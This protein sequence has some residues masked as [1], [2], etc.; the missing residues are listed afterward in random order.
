MD[1]T[2]FTPGPWHL[3]DIGDYTDFGGNSRV[4][5]SERWSGDDPYRLAV[6]HTAKGYET[7]EAN[8]ALIAAAPDLYVA[9]RDLC[10]SGGPDDGGCVIEKGIAALRK[11]RG[12]T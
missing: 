1:E 9:L 8:S 10:A 3:C 4:I 6:V 5:M 2:K 12:E 11:A 7:G